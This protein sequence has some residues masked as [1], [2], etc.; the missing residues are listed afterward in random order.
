[1]SFLARLI[2][3]LA[4][5]V[6]CFAASSTSTKRGLGVGATFHSGTAFE[7]LQAAWY[8]DWGTHADPVMAT[9][10]LPFTPMFWSTSCLYNG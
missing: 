8:Y 10:N 5:L 4:L 3:V 1:M 7:Q 2:F 6:S 9:S